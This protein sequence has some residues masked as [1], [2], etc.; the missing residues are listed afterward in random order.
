V[1][2]VVK[3][4]LT[5]Q[6][7]CSG[8]G[9]TP[10]AYFTSGNNRDTSF[11]TKGETMNWEQIRGQWRQLKG[12]IKAKWGKLTDDD[13]DVIAGQQEQLIGKIQERYGIAKEEAHRHA[14]QQIS[15]PHRNYRSDGPFSPL[16]AC[17]REVSRYRKIS[18]VLR[19]GTP[20]VG[21]TNH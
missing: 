6:P 12:A 8:A 2:V 21:G 1:I 20:Q 4:I 14:L 10:I 16:W 9:K 17:A 5:Y 7:L 15:F 19:E 13:L 18:G 11:V 3:M